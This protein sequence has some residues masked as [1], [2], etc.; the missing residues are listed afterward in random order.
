MRIN[1]K[2]IYITNR[3]IELR[4]IHIPVAMSWSMGR[5]DI[6]I[7]KMTLMS[8]RPSGLA[9]L[10]LANIKLVLKYLKTSRTHQAVK[11][12]KHMTAFFSLR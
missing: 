8:K 12:K 6:N 5:F 4:D 1:Y 7:E 11:N 2:T 3:V 9:S 10:T